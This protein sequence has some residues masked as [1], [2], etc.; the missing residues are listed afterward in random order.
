[1]MKR[2]CERCCEWCWCCEI[3]DGGAVNGVVNA[4]EREPARRSVFA[5]DCLVC[6][7]CLCLSV[8]ASAYQFCVCLCFPLCVCVCLCVSV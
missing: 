2:R 3:N 7:C 8:C 5:S 4:A 6:V 1:V